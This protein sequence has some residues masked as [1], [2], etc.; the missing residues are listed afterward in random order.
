MCGNKFHEFGVA[1]QV[2]LLSP[3]EL[4]SSHPHFLSLHPPR[5]LSPGLSTRWRGSGSF[6]HNVRRRQDSFLIG[7]FSLSSLARVSRLELI[8]TARFSSDHN[9][10]SRWRN[11]SPLASQPKHKENFTLEDRLRGVLA[12]S[13]ILTS[14][15]SQHTFP[16]PSPPQPLF[17][18]RG[19][20]FHSPSLISHRNNH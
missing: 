4:S 2:P 3:S 17:C 15:A 13:R 14:K 20:L 11:R 8:L 1:T 10:R 19:N 6:C 16:P 7:F 18:L 12:S 9:V 5:L